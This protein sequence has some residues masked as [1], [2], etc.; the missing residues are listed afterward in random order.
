LYAINDLLKQA[1]VANKIFITSIDADGS[2]LE[3]ENNTLKLNSSQSDVMISFSSPLY[4]KPNKQYYKYR[5]RYK[6]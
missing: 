3:L 1:R 6:V 5:Y 2:L 4:V